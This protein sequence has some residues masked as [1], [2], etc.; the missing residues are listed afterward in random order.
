MVDLFESYVGAIIAAIAIG[1]T[2]S[3]SAIMTLAQNGISNDH[4]RMSLMTLPLDISAIGLIASVIGIYSM[5][6]LK[7]IGPSAALR[8]STYIAAGVFIFLALIVVWALGIAHA[9]FWAVTSGCLVGLAI[10]RSLCFR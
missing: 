8:Y 10:G 3:V 4:I 5:R 6:V 2:L 9:V 1:A 7:D